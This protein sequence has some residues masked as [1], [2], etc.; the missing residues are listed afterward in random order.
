[1]MKEASSGW[2]TNAISPADSYYIR[3]VNKIF[4]ETVTIWGV[5]INKLYTQMQTNAR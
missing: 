3:P 2:K 4:E 5:N 1:M